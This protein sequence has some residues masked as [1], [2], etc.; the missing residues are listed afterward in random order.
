[1]PKSIARTTFQGSFHDN[2]LELIQNFKQ[3]PL[4]HNK[5]PRALHTV[6][7]YLCFMIQF[8][9]RNVSIRQNGIIPFRSFSSFAGINLWFLW[10]LDRCKWCCCYGNRVA[11]WYSCN[12]GGVC[13]KRWVICGPVL[14][15][16]LQH[17][18][19][20]PR[21]LNCPSK[22]RRWLA[23]I[24]WLNLGYRNLLESS[25]FLLVDAFCFDFSI[26]NFFNNLIRWG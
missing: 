6:R 18:R 24:Q 17:T 4:A 5:L 25:F 19:S 23:M 8:P 2:S 15:R 12:K 1:M 26:C 16:A 20:N 21:W 22:L 11:N 14:H 9:G 13:C 10:I 3:L 7:N